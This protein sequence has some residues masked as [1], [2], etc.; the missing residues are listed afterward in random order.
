ML[1]VNGTLCADGEACVLNSE[2][3][4]GFIDCSDR[5][6]EDNC[7]G[8]TLRDVHGVSAIDCSTIRQ[9]NCSCR[10]TLFLHFSGDL[11]VYKIQNLQWSA[12]FS[13]AVTLTWSRPKN[14]PPTSC[15]FVIYFRYS[16][17][18]SSHL[19]LR[20]LSFFQVVDHLNFK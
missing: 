13:G 8:E 10:F 5:S 20:L 16:F 14:M 7:T 2:R 12:N 18:C 6:D 3:C 19:H 17:K 11:L 4:D 9:S 1:C 15:S